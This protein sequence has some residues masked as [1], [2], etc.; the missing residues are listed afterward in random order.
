MVTIYH[1]L[2]L[3]RGVCLLQLHWG[4]WRCCK[5]QSEKG[6]TTEW[7]LTPQHSPDVNSA[8]RG[9]AW[10]RLSDARVRAQCESGRNNRCL[11][12][13]GEQL[14]AGDAEHRA[15]NPV[16]K[17]LPG[18]PQGDWDALGDLGNVGCVWAGMQ[19]EHMAVLWVCVLFLDAA[20]V[21]TVKLRDPPNTSLF[22]P[23]GCS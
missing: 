3:S 19:D 14:G 5:P 13:L 10:Y 4:T 12:V 16:G 15:V 22:L 1:F 20:P 17:G 9:R 21:L 11:W 7:G 23:L 18:L 2:S 6:Q 8:I